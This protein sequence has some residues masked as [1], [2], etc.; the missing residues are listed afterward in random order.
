MLRHFRRHFGISAP[1]LTV[2][3]HLG[4]HWRAVIWTTAIVIIAWMIWWGFDF[5]RFLAGFDSSAAGRERAQLH[6]EAQTLRVDNESLRTR[7]IQLESEL[8]VAKGAQATL[9][10]QTL[11]LQSENTQIKQELVFLH[12]LMA[13]TSKDGA[14]LI[15]RVQVDREAGDTYRYQI[16]LVSG[17]N[18]EAEFN[19]RLQLQVILMQSGQRSTITLPDDQPASKMAMALNFK[20]YQRVEGT[21]NVPAGSRVKSVQARLFENGKSEPRAMHTLNLPS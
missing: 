6:E 14:P 5:G 9:S 11:A 7:T 21:F 1:R 2:R 12:R 4:W 3:T 8:Q 17:G 19:G 15:Q 18:S 10:K 16:L 13:G 20:Y